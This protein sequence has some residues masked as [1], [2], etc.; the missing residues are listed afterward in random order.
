MEIE[1]DLHTET[2]KW[3]SKLSEQQNKFLC[4]KKSLM[5]KTFEIL[6]N[7]KLETGYLKKL[8]HFC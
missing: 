7:L 8:Q 3:N 6:K 4:F 5:F 1:I 2:I